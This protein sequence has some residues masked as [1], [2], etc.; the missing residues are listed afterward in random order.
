KLV[1]EIDGLGLKE[2]SHF[3]RNIGMMKNLAILDRHI[4]KCLKYYG[5]IKEIPK[6]LTKKNYLEIEKRMIEFS[7]KIKI[8]PAKIDLLFW[9][10]QTGYVFK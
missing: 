6:T 10:E 9:S 8:E 7:K 4:L 2:A 1:K 5:V 3:L